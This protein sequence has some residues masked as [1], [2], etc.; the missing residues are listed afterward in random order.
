MGGR[1]L[2]RYAVSISIET[3]WEQRV[4]ARLALETNVL[5][6]PKSSVQRLYKLLMELNRI[7]TGVCNSISMLELISVKQCLYKKY[8]KEEEVH[9]GRNETC[10]CM[11]LLL[12]TGFYL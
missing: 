12:Q 3:V 8:V 10:N 11:K 4:L 5:Q 6:T 2:L 7:Y 9:V 1:A